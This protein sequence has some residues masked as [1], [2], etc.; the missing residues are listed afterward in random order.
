MNVLYLNF[1]LLERLSSI[2]TKNHAD[3][4]KWLATEI[5]NFTSI[6]T[7]LFKNFPKTKHSLFLRVVA[8]ETWYLDF[9]E[10]SGELI[11]LFHKFRLYS[12][13]A[14]VLLL[15]LP[16]IPDIETFWP[17][18]IFSFKARSISVYLVYIPCA[19]TFNST[20]AVKR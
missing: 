2:L 14:I 9:L 18:F 11:I 17:F 13:F 7:D 1:Y 3:G 6:L 5:N 12:N 15:W 19:D 20:F 10:I 16:W 8:M 4:D